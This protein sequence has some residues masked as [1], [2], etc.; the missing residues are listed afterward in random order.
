MNGWDVLSDAIK[1]GVPSLL[2]GLVAF[3]IG[4]A[5]RSHEFEKE[6]RR[7]K[8]DF[9]EVLGD[10]LEDFD[11][12]LAVL[13]AY[14]ADDFELSKTEEAKAKFLA[15]YEACCEAGRKLDNLESRFQLM[16]FSDCIVVNELTRR[17]GMFVYSE[18][19]KMRNG[20]AEPQIGLALDGFQAQAT[21]LREALA[22][23]YRKL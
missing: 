16:G 6:R 1:I 13:H 22:L 7:R 2:T 11:N 12:S 23:E 21:E 8:H 19:E 18:I 15:E 20:L 9:L 5:A 4:R 17:A 14:C 10:N 3:F